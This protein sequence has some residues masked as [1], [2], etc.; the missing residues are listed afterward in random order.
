ML[1]GLLGHSSIW[2]ACHESVSVSIQRPQLLNTVKDLGF[3]KEIFQMA[4][5]LSPT[6]LSHS[7]CGTGTSG[8]SAL[9]SAA[10]N[11]KRTLLAATPFILFLPCYLFL[12]FSSWSYPGGL[13]A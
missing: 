8:G 3:G 5:L 4:Q 7:F 6:K 9:Y 12:L 11:Q 2:V 10:K 13:S 1:L